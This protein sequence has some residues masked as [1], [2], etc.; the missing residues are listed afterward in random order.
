[1]AR[2]LE[3]KSYSHEIKLSSF[4]CPTI[5]V[6]DAKLIAAARRKSQ[7]QARCVFKVGEPGGLPANRVPSSE[8]TE[9]QHVQADVDSEARTTAEQ[10]KIKR[11]A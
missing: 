6:S 2:W 9:K 4:Y 10:V 3:H 1:M 5:C 11:E 8:L 7:T